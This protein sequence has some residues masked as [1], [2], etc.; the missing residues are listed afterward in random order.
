MQDLEKQLDKYAD[1]LINKGCNL[2]PG[3]RLIIKAPIEAVDFVRILVKK[4]YTKGA[5]FVA[6][7]WHDDITGKLRFEH[8]PDDSFDYYP[9]WVKHSHEDIA[10]NHDC[11]L[12][13]SG[14][15]PELLADQDQSKIQAVQ[16]AVNTHLKK[17]RELLMK[18]N[19]SW[20]IGAYPVQAWAAKVFPKD[21]PEEQINKLWE[22]ILK[23]SR[24]DNNDPIQAW[25]EH[26]SAL[27]KNCDYLNSKQY[28]S[29]HYKASGTDLTIGLPKGHIW[30]AAED[31]SKD[32][33]VYIANIPTEEIFTLP[34]YSRV[35]GKVSSTKTL[36]Y[37]GVL[38]ENF[39]FEFKDGKAISVKAERGQEALE[40]LLSLDDWS[41][42]LGEVALV[43]HS[44]PISASGLL[45]YN[46]L[47]DENASCHIALGA[48]YNF[49]L[50][51]GNDMDEDEFRKAG[52]NK[53]IAHTDF[54]I[55]SDELDIDGILED[56]IRE[57]IMRGGEWAF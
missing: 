28:T 9:D 24:V 34:D 15:D 25:S 36:N 52:G 35:D 27:K 37:S 11:V 53:S 1:L 44:S 51:G 18:Q 2:Q 17:F 21:N 3:K 20:C 50:T 4:A 19:F 8:A 55:G 23:T 33:N 46:T 31:V 56:G 12:T 16:K 49:T 5:K 13:L 45:F 6:V 26:V 30:C 10:E 57:S 42:Y 41:S 40:K 43:P 39:E 48:A 7:Q 22:A 14:D 47:F 32:G 54:M 38:C 29:L